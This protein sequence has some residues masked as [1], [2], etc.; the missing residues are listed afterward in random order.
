MEYLQAH[1][2]AKESVEDDILKQP[3]VTGVAV[4]YKYVGGKRTDEVSIQV[5]VKEKKKTVPKAQMIPAEINGIPTDVIERKFELHPA[6]KKVL[7][8]EPMADT[9]TYNPVRGGISIGPCRAV[10]GF[11]FAGTLGIPVRDRATGNPL[12]LSKLSRDVRGQ[13]LVCG[14]SDDA[15]EPRGY[16]ILSRWRGRD[17]V[18]CSADVV[19]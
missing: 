15:A 18:A 2:R 7:E 10:G 14:R 12:L 17:A 11:V 9:V 4:G 19:G 16:G 3:G 5:F 13:R 1:V 8:L 6:M